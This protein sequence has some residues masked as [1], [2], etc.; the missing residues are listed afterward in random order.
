MAGRGRKTISTM[1][2]TEPWRSVSM[3]FPGTEPPVEPAK[4]APAATGQSWPESSDAQRV[5]VIARR[6]Q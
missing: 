1:V 5:V 6:P 2:G 3:D 4:V